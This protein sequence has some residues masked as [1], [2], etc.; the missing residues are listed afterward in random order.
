[1]KSSLSFSYVNTEN[2][3]TILI[4]KYEKIDEAYLTSSKFLNFQKVNEITIADYIIES[5]YIHQSMN[6]Y[7]I[8]MV[9]LRVTTPLYFSPK[10]PPPTF[11]K[12]FQ[13][14]IKDHTTP[15]PPPYP[16]LT[17]FLQTPLQTIFFKQHFLLIQLKTEKIVDFI[18][19]NTLLCFTLFLLNKLLIT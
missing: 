5:K 13:P 11:Q 6:N 3:M 14:S 17:I 18:Y 16:A 19:S 9:F 7:E 12:Y 1:M 15:P 4:D 8:S 10:P 2:G